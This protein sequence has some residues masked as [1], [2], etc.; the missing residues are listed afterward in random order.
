V[1]S[2]SVD[3]R[4]SIGRCFHLSEVSKRDIIAR[5]LADASTTSLARVLRYVITFAPATSLLA[6]KDEREL[7]IY[8]PI[9]SIV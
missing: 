8:G 3:R 7:R 9:D 4:T 1:F 6:D 2:P 5:V